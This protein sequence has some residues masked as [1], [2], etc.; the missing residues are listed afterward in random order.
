MRSDVFAAAIDGLF[1]DPNLAGDATYVAQGNAPKLIRVIS[2]RPDAITEF[3]EARL[4]SETQM[5]DLRATDV[6]EPQSGDRIEIGNE[7]FVVQ[8]KPVRDCERL[9]WTVN[10]RPA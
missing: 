5:F 10:A 7:A 4:W 3:G 6:A 1:G 9:I 8:G 2:R